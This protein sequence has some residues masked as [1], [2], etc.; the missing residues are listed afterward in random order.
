[1]F[2]VR[3]E[4]VQGVRAVRGELVQGSVLQKGSW[5]REVVL[6]ERSWCRELCVL[7]E[8]SWCRPWSACASGNVRNI[9]MSMKKGIDLSREVKREF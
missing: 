5:C 8:G 2:A 4:L 6:Y 1:M 9:P 3:G 7:Y